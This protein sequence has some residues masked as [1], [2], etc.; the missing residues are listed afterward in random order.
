[1]AGFIF[2]HSFRGTFKQ[3][4]T[5]AIPS[6]GAQVNNIIRQFYYIHIVFNNQNAISPVHQFTHYSH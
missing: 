6:F 1:M 5:A 2:E 4:F 3:Y